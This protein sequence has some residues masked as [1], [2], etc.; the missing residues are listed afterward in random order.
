[1]VV[2]FFANGTWTYCM[3]VLFGLSSHIPT[4]L[5]PLPVATA[6]GSSLNL[7]WAPERG[8]I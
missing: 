6:V 2:L 7:K 3:A 1:M 8:M 5:H 4:F